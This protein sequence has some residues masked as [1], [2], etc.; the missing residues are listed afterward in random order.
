MLSD[1]TRT[2]RQAKKVAFFCC[3]ICNF[4]MALL[5]C[6]LIFFPS[7]RRMQD[8]YHTMYCLAGLGALKFSF[9][10]IPLLADVQPTHPVHNISPHQLEKIQTFFKN[11]NL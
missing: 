2:A 1:A 11:K 6:I 7:N 9:P 4:P 3:Y 8:Y 10:S 5:H